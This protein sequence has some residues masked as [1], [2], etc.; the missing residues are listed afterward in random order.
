MRS[1]LRLLTQTVPG[2]L[3]IVDLWLNASDECTFSMK[4]LWKINVKIGTNWRQCWNG[5]LFCPDVLSTFVVK[6]MFDILFI[7]FYNPFHLQISR[8]SARPLVFTKQACRTWQASWIGSKEYCCP[9]SRNSSSGYLAFKFRDFSCSIIIFARPS[10]RL[11]S[12]DFTNS[13]K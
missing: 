10:S 11:R 7:V 2:D 13:I 8:L 3:Y 9:S 4:P 6:Y 5:A 12:E 1:M